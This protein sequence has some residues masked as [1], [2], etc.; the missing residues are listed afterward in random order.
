MLP[1][2][3]PL[4]LRYNVISETLARQL[5]GSYTAARAPSERATALFERA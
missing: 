3:D 4:D 2:A 1:G 5:A